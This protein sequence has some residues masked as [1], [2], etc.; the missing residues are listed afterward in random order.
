M[1]HLKIFSTEDLKMYTSPRKGEIKFG[2]RIGTVNSLETLKESTAKYVIFGIPE[3][4]GVRANLGKS[5]T[6]NAFNTFLNAFLN[7]QVNQFN[8]PENVLLL[9]EIDC[10]NWLIKA[11]HIEDNDPNISAKLHDILIEIDAEVSQL[12][13]TIISLGKIPIIIG[14]GH[15]NA[16][17]NIKGASEAISNPINVINIDAHTDLRTTNYRHSGNGFS[18]AQEQGYLNFYHIFG[19]HK[20]Y[21]PDYIFKSMNASKFIDYTLFDDILSDT[22]A[23]QA[24]KEALNQISKSAFG[25]E[26]DCDAISG[27]PSSAQTPSGM[28][29]ETIRQ[30]IAE[31]ITHNT[32]HYLHICEAKPSE[33]YPTGKAIS[34]MVS[35]FIRQQ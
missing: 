31:S 18:Y 10:K 27:F 28:S 32:C 8:T 23:I 29:L 26:I 25:L 12:V 4:I 35:D 7:I 33:Y 6:K 30:C 11:S 24:Y 9:G 22:I 5:G 19:L 20:N 16:Y 17:G 14:G 3:D 13:K 1:K 21:T 2:E 34:Y 15:N